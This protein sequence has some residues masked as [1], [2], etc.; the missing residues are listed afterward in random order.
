MLHGLMLGATFWPLGL[1]LCEEET[2]YRYSSFDC[3]D[4]R[5]ELEGVS[6]CDDEAPFKGGRTYGDITRRLAAP[7]ENCCRTRVSGCFRL[8]WSITS[9][10]DC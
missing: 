6:S 1:T 9:H 10:L 8:R 2:D 3:A 4:A 5:R 7:D